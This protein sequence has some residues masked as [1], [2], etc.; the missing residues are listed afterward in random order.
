[1]RFLSAASGCSVT[2]LGA[3]V[4]ADIWDVKERG[5]A[6]SVYYLGP[7]CGPT[8]GPLI[9]GAFIQRWGWRATQWFLVVYCAAILIGIVFGLPETLR[10]S[11]QHSVITRRHSI[12]EDDPRLSYLTLQG[13]QNTTKAAWHYLIDPLRALNYLRFSII[14]TTIYLAG[15]TFGILIA[16][17]ISLQQAYSNPPYNFS[18]VLIGLT[19]LPLGIGSVLGSIAGGRWSDAIMDRRARA[20]A[21]YDEKGTVVH[22]PEDRIRENAW[23]SILAFPAALIWYGWTV[24]KGITWIVP[25]SILLSN[26]YET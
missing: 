25:V 14:A 4:I 23:I 17:S 19:F 13:F 11:K 18:P 26:I 7:L 22:S 2:T 24:D 9:G 10:D 6:M 21:R 3:A 20:V 8:L 5:R 15:I 12:R 16:F 1:M